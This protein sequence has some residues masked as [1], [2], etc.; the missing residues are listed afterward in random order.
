[1]SHNNQTN[2]AF[3]VEVFIRKSNTEKPIS[4]LYSLLVI[5]HDKLWTTLD[6]FSSQICYFHGTL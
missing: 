5:T 6:E 3:R 2:M 4:M 1:M